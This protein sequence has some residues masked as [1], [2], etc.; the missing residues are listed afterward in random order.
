MPKYSIKEVDFTHD[1]KLISVRTEAGHTIYLRFSKDIYYDIC[2]GIAVIQVQLNNWVTS[3]R[4]EQ[5]LSSISKRLETLDDQKARDY[6]LL[7]SFGSLELYWKK[8][9]QNKGRKYT[10]VEN[11]KPRS[12]IEK[13][14][15]KHILP[16]LFSFRYSKK[17]TRLRFGDAATTIILPYDELTEDRIVLI[18]HSRLGDE[19]IPWIPCVRNIEEGIGKNQIHVAVVNEWIKLPDELRK[20]RDKIWMRREVALSRGEEY[21][22]CGTTYGLNS[23]TE[24][25]GSI[26]ER[27]QLNL[28]LRPTDYYTFMA[29]QEAMNEPIFRD[30]QGRPISGR[31]KYLLDIDPFIPVPLM[32]QSISATVLPIFRDGQ[33]EYTLFAKRASRDIL[34]TG[35]NVFALPINETPRRRPT[36]EERRNLEDVPDHLLEDDSLEDGNL[37]I[38][39][40]IRGAKEELGIELPEESIKIL[41]FGLSTQRYFYSMVGIARTELPIKY[42]LNCLETARDGRLEYKEFH[43]IPFDPESVYNFMI[44]NREWGES[45]RLG[46]YFALAHCFGTDRI[47][48]LFEDFPV[49]IKA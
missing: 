14:V 19:F 46:A 31:E 9:F 17:S 47:S 23:F 43:P 11:I 30:Q 5:V 4:V 1:G 15:N 37:F 3:D 49:P 45:S 2:F 44:T 27:P 48:R 39:G 33:E 22:W 24:S 35:R 28:V 25:R 7:K 29:V 40:L 41:A 12:L 36:D 34:A 10:F 8:H 38:N 26:S 42:V 6:G 32:A 21:P 18:D 16:E 20:I 13:T